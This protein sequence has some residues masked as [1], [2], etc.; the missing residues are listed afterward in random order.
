M[1]EPCQTPRRDPDVRIPWSKA[2]GVEK[3]RVAAGEEIRTAAAP[4]VVRQAVASL[5]QLLSKA[6][7]EFRLLQGPDVLEVARLQEDLEFARGRLAA[8]DPNATRPATVSP[9]TPAPA[10]AVPPR[11]P[12]P[13]AA[14]DRQPGPQRWCSTISV[15]CPACQL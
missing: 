15:A 4:D 1:C 13:A 12:A 8:L 3:S 5:E 14:P 10:A 2:A 6:Q 11:P 9:Q 7:R